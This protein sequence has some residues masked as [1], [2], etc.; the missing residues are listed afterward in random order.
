MGDADN[1]PPELKAEISLTK[2]KVKIKNIVNVTDAAVA[3][4]VKNDGSAINYGSFFI[5]I[6]DQLKMRK[7]LVLVLT[8]DSKYTPTPPNNDRNVGFT[9]FDMSGQ[10]RYRNLWEH[11]YR[12]CQGVIFVVDS[13]D[14]LRMV[15]AKDEL[16]M[17][18]QVP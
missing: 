14:R 16:D 17:L 8:Q 11:Y 4:F 2:K 12:D 7:A 6:S 18:L 9:A 15:V 10:G 1:L 5:N 3:D 13:S